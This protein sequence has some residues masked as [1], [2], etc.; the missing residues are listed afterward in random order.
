MELE[1]EKLTIGYDV[2][3]AGVDHIPFITPTVGMYKPGEAA[4]QGI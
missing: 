4:T 3:R 1:I 2:L